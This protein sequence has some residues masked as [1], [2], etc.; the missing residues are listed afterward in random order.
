MIRPPDA[1][2]TT[3]GILNMATNTGFPL[4]DAKANRNMKDASKTASSQATALLYQGVD[5]GS[6]GRGTRH[7]VTGIPPRS[8]HEP[9]PRR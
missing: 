1:L 5:G 3:E 8:A 9:G 4:P 2:G 6:I 7:L